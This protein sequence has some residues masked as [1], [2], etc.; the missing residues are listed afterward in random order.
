MKLTNFVCFI[1]YILF[2]NYIIISGLKKIKKG[3]CTIF[4]CKALIFV[5]QYPTWQIVNISR[6]ISHMATQQIIFISFLT[7]KSKF[8]TMHHLI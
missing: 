3:L 8:I 6:L 1:I 2:Q 4:L 5:S 7:P